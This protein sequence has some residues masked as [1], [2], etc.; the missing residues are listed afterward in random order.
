MLSGTLRSRHCA[1]LAPQFELLM[2]HDL[3]R[4]LV[5]RMHC[6]SSNYINL[7][8]YSNPA[9]YTLGDT[10]IETECRGCGIANENFSLAKNF[11]IWSENRFRIGADASN[12]FIR[13]TWWFINGAVGPTGFGRCGVVSRLSGRFRFTVSSFSKWQTSGS[14]P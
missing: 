8:A 11:T 7:L 13:H 12:A 6:R 10:L 4:T 9:S 14:R 5:Q 3:F 1:R 2:H